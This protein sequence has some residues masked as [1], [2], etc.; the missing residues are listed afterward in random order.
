M[1]SLSSHD[2]LL[3]S[4]II[5]L[6]LSLRAKAKPDQNEQAVHDTRYSEQDM[7]DALETSYEIW[8]SGADKSTAA[9]QA[10]AALEIMLGKLGE[11]HAANKR[12]SQHDAGRGR[13]ILVHRH[14]ARQANIT[15]PQ[16]TRR[17]RKVLPQT[18]ATR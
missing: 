8:Q 17:I 4:M 7:R 9:R 13:R 1:S 5:C 18:R 11:T 2:F 16:A 10:R 14:F 3:S 15:N 12:S 6:E